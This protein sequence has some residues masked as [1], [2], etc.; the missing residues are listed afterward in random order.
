M[1]IN[2][3]R[4]IICLL[5]VFISTVSQ[6]QSDL[7]IYGV[8]KSADGNNLAN[9]EVFIKNS[10]SGTKTDSKGYYEIKRLTKGSYELAAFYMGMKSEMQKVT[11][12]NVDVKL[13]FVLEE[14]TQNLDAV[15][16]TAEKEETFGVRRLNAVEGAA[17][18]EAKKNEVLVMKDINANLATNNARQ[19]FSKVAGLNIWESDGAGLQLEI[20]ARGLNP[21]RTAEFNTRQNGYDISADPLGY[22]ESYYTPPAEALQRVEVVRGAASLQYGPQFGGM[23]NFVMKEGPEDKP[24]E[25]TARL[26]TGSYGLLNSFT[27]LGGKV[28]K[29][30][31][32]SFYNYKQGGNFRANSDYEYHAGYTNLSYDISDKLS[33]GIDVTVMRYTAQQPGGLTDEQFEEDPTMVTRSRNWFD[34]AWNLFNWNIDY[35]FND[36]LRLN[37]RTFMLLAHRKALGVLETGI[38]AGVGRTQRD[39]MWDEYNNWGN[40]TRLIYQYSTFGHPSTLLVGTRYFSGDL[41][42]RQGFGPDTEGA[43]FWFDYEGINADILPPGDVKNDY[44]FPNKNFAA[45]AENIFFLHDKFSVTP[46][47]RFESFKTNAEGYYY[48]IVENDRTGEI[49]S[50]E[51]SD[52]ESKTYPRQL[53]LLGLGASY[54]PSETLELYG[55]FS[56]NYRAVNFNDFRV[57]N[58][59]KEID[60][61][62]QDEKGYNV[63]LGLRGQLAGKLSFDISAFMLYYNNKI[64]NINQQSQRGSH[65]VNF[66]T[67]IGSSRNIGLE[68]FF[69][70]DIISWLR[71][72]SA[73]KLNI[74]SNFTILDARYVNV[75]KGSTDG[76]IEGNQ[77]ENVPP[78]IFRSGLSYAYR[79]FKLS[80]QFSYT[81][82][83]YTDAQ[84][85]GVLPASQGLVGPI[86]SYYVMDLSLKYK[87]NWLQVETGV[88]NLLDE[89]YFTRRADGYPGPGIIPANGRAF[90]FALQVKLP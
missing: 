69:E 5:A 88:N 9:A 77:V 60:E 81:A 1:K 78:I 33:T 64:G 55:N 38:D 44:R 3:Y 34:V 89:M 54:K 43:D 27:S 76:D 36:R 23:I 70:T 73:S 71:S 80:Y 18:Y 30:K 26:T 45:F 2:I 8:V 87:Y 84:N 56:Q 39:L 75:T 28:G 67:N 7:K 66:V 15:N 86:P 24:A 68:T 47:I 58:P 25:V 51:K 29:L 48:T 74:Y 46:G 10:S 20:G 82:E 63:D 21:K 50:V 52:P 17:I 85:S 62:I 19:V 40:E 61:N 4:I 42:R 31:H 12:Q 49:E 65:S 37:S 59:N 14:I 11:L 90:Y 22:P 35:E 6:A 53:I 57:D 72:E 83:H 79:N 41:H 13:D 16:V 32:Y